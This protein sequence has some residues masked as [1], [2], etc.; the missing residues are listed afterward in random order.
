MIVLLL[1]PLRLLLSPALLLTHRATVG[2]VYLRLVR[3]SGGET[4]LCE[5]LEFWVGRLLRKRGNH[6]RGAAD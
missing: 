5:L 4:S 2:A 1:L 6:T 3:L